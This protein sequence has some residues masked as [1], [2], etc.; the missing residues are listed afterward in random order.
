MSFVLRREAK[1]SEPSSAPESPKLLRPGMASSEPPIPVTPPKSPART[2]ED[3][4][5][6][7][8]TMGSGSGDLS[9]KDIVERTKKPL[10][11]GPLKTLREREDRE[12]AQVAAGAAP[13]RNQQHHQQ[14][15]N[16][17]HQTHRHETQHHGSSK[18]KVIVPPKANGDKMQ[19][20]HRSSGERNNSS[21]RSSTSSSKALGDFLETSRKSNAADSFLEAMSR[22][23]DA[24]PRG[25][26]AISSSKMPPPSPS[27]SSP[28]PS[29]SEPPRSSF[30]E[31]PPN[32]RPVTPTHHHQTPSRSP[33]KTSLKSPSGG[34]M[35]PMS[36]LA[37]PNRRVSPLA[38]ASYPSV[39]RPSF[40][41][42]ETGRRRETPPRGPPPKESWMPPPSPPRRS[43]VGASPLGEAP[44][45]SIG[46][47]E[48]LRKNV[49]GDLYKSNQ[50]A[51]AAA[52]AS[53]TT[54]A[55]AAASPFQSKASVDP[56]KNCCICSSYTFFKT[57][58]LVCGKIYCRNCVKDG[59]GKMPEGRKCLKTCLGKP[60][61]SKY[62]HEA[63]NG[64]F[65]FVS[66]AA[67]VAEMNWAR[68]RNPEGVTSNTSPRHSNGS[69]A[70]PARSSGS[71]AADLLPMRRSKST[72]SPH[73]QQR[74]IVT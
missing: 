5:K 64:C 54:T 45:S 41:D 38:S 12:A 35:A 28:R 8:E 62:I 1:I 58:C 44:R 60:I 73:P 33:L 25:K 6:F 59:M 16:H 68:W 48:S 56:S 51:A 29:F 69:A 27:R 72:Q 22:I 55:A 47:A 66:S 3:L 14:H 18:P 23:P 17:Q 49:L 52:A 42:P 43:S 9:M 40:G 34:S 67:S 7:Y 36:P 63:G 61:H 30:G 37:S 31:P 11:K 70:T 24:S 39:R 71:S 32:Y 74:L 4:F 21:A 15:Q 53:T 20:A 46:D 50:K 26:S 10:P 57:R 2:T 13:G 65:C 19:G